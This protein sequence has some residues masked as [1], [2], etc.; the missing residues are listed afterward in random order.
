[1]YSR[2]TR[3]AIVV[4]H[5]DLA[6][7]GSRYAGRFPSSRS[8][9]EVLRVLEVLVEIGL[10]GVAS[11]RSRRFLRRDRQLLHVRFCHRSLPYTGSCRGG[12]RCAGCRPV[13]HRHGGRLHGERG[14]VFRLQGV[15]VGAL[16]Q[17]RA[18]ICASIVRGRRNKTR[19]AARR[20][21]A[22]AQHRVLGRGRPPATA[23]VAVI[24]V[25]GLTP[26]PPDSPLPQ[27]LV[28][29]QRH[30]R[31]MA[32]SDGIGAERQRLGHVRS[33]ADAAGIDQRD[34]AGPPRSSSAL[35]AWRIE[36]FPYAGT[37]DR[38]CGPALVPP[39]MPSM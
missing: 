7:S 19:S 33:V 21:R 37:L 20:G 25:A 22:A 10:L 5:Q 1:M 8:G 38:R 6:S 35:R 24:A 4:E 23:G 30:Q 11:F 27:C 31:R 17:A 39:S 32:D 34:L 29:V 36:R 15:H 18:I 14:Q 3:H 28:A 9:V 16:P 13:D 26:F 12:R 2:G